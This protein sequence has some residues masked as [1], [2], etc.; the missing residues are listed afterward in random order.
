MK[1]HLKE[2]MVV[3]DISGDIYEILA[4]E[5]SRDNIYYSITF[6]VLKSQYRGDDG[7][8]LTWLY[9]FLTEAIPI[10]GYN[11]PLWRLLNE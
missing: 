9:Q 5:T 7:R 3:R 1:M 11:T 2:G 4:I 6:K 8:K 10:P